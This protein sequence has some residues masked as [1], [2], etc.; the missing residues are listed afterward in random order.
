MFARAHWRSLY[1]G[2]AFVGVL[3]VGVLG[4]L[5]IGMMRR[6]ARARQRARVRWLHRVSPWLLRTTG[7]RCDYERGEEILP[8]GGGMTVLNH[9]SYVDVLLIASRYPVVF[10]TSTEVR[11]GSALGPLCKLAG[12]AFVDRRSASKMRGEIT[13]LAQLM[14][15]GLNVVVFPEATSTRGDRVLPFKA[16]MFEAVRVAERPLWVARVSYPASQLRTAS[17]AGDDVFIGHLT[18][19]LAAPAHTPRVTWLAHDPQPGARDA[20]ELARWAREV[21][22]GESAPS[23]P[24]ARARQGA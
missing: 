16:G 24:T 22:V 23:V 12:G 8:H 4:S 18:G 9:I 14:R 7:V 21:V 17:Y 19:L 5:S 11:D 2:P 6:D 20:R 13:A 1:R 10:V 3:L 15:E